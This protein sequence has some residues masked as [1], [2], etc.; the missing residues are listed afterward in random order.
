MEDKGKK[1]EFDL[2]VATLKF[3]KIKSASSCPLINSIFTFASLITSSQTS[4]TFFEYFAANKGYDIIGLLN[5]GKTFLLGSPLLPPRP[6]NKAII[7][8]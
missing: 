1:S 6:I 5:I 8:L 2:Y 3:L 4:S 7:I